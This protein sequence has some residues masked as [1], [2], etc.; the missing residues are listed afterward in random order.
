MRTRHIGKV[1]PA[2][3]FDIVESELSRELEIYYQAIHSYPDHFARTRLTFQRHLMNMMG[4]VQTGSQGSA[5][6]CLKSAS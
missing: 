1:Y 5:S 4:M 2:V 3:P 6:E